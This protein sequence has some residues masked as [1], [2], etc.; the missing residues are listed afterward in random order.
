MEITAFVFTIE[1]ERGKWDETQLVSVE[2][3]LAF[4]FLKRLFLKNWTTV[5]SKHH[6]LSAPRST[7]FITPHISSFC[8]KHFPG[9]WSNHLFHFDFLLCSALPFRDTIALFC[10]PPIIYLNKL[11]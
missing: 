8:S 10:R 7:N 1:P 5:V 2:G 9:T 4:F 3:F 11:F 6:S